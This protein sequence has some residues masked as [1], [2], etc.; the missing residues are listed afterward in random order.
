MPLLTST[1]WWMETQLALRHIFSQDSDFKERMFAR[2]M[3]VMKGQAWNV[4]ETLKTSDHGPLE[5]TRRPRVYVW[6]DVVDIPVAV[7]LV[8]PSAETRRRRDAA[9]QNGVDHEEM[10]ISA[11]NAST[12]RPQYDILGLGKSSTE[13]PNANRFVLPGAHRGANGIS[14]GEERK[15]QSPTSPATIDGVDFAGFND[16]PNDL[17]SMRGPSDPLL[18]GLS[19]WKSGSSLDDPPRRRHGEPRSRRRRY[20][21][22]GRRG[23][24]NGLLYDDDL[25]GDL[26]YAAAEGMEKNQRK[27]IVERLEQVKAQNP[28]FTCC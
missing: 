10:D 13:L 11:A 23:S 14:N 28:V 7:P 5:L 1:K 15:P 16:D 21:L 3:A 26:G 4:V 8:V 20:S 18:H 17:T 22:A 24:S 2:Q 6:D 19:K 25:E 9:L 27:V 12:A